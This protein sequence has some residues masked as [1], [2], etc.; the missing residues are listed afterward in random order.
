[1]TL[2]LTNELSPNVTPS[3]PMSPRAKR[4]AA[5]LPHPCVDAVNIRYS[6]TIAFALRAGTHR[7]ALSDGIIMPSP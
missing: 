4:S 5:L 6:A 3:L 7:F 1:V 2:V